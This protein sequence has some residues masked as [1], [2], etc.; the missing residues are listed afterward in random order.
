MKARNQ[1]KKTTTEAIASGPAYEDMIL[2]GLDFSSRNMI[3][4]HFQGCSLRQCKFCDADMSYVRFVD[5]DLYCVDFTGAMLYACWFTDCDL[6]KAVF[7]DSYM[8]GMR[9]SGV[10]VTHTDF[11]KDIRLG[12]NRKAV[13]ISS[14][15][16]TEGA[17]TFGA[18]LPNVSEHEMSRDSILVK[19]FYLKINLRDDPS[20]EGWRAWRRRSELCTI[21][22]RV[23]LENCSYENA[24]SFYYDVR[25]Y[26]R[27]SLPIGIHRASDWFFGDCLWG[28]GVA[29]QRAVVS[30]FV[31]VSLFAG[32]YLLLPTFIKGSGLL[33]GQPPLLQFSPGMDCSAAIKSL[34]YAFYFSLMTATTAAYGDVMPEGWAKFVA[35][36]QV[37]CGVVLFS[38][39]V[40]S[41]ARR[42]ANV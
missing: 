24:M 40:A 26:R 5:C 3:G 16:E 33:V 14:E 11:G 13:V 19:G 17:I 15:G 37:V 41:V 36:L 22:K 42:I 10:D 6:T 39:L 28:F 32:I 31:S 34:G 23:L 12:R 30:L 7:A 21:V 2:D 8:S 29:W 4:A 20:D 9:M 35:V 25:V 18:T 27:K 38:L 1:I